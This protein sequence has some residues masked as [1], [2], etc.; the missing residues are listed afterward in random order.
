MDSFFN[1]GPLIACEKDDWDE[2]PKSGWDVDLGP[3]G[4]GL[5]FWPAGNNNEWDTWVVNR[6]VPGMKCDRPLR[7]EFYHE[8]EGDG[9][10]ELG[11]FNEVQV[12]TW[13]E[14]TFANAIAKLKEIYGEDNVSVKIGLIFGSS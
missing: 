9:I 14:L 13:V 5:M 6:D 8:L 7:S 12:K 11:G 4:E 3:D 10:Y 1:Y 2:T